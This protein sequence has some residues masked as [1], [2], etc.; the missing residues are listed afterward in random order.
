MSYINNQR[1]GV[2]SRY[3]VASVYTSPRSNQA[4]VVVAKADGGEDGKIYNFTSAAQAAEIFTADSAGKTMRGC[5]SV[6]FAAGVSRVVAVPVSDSQD[7][8]A[9]FGLIENVGGIGAVICD[10]TEVANLKALKLSVEKSSGELRERIAF[11]GATADSAK[12]TA[13][14]INSERFVLTA[15]S[16]KLEDGSDHPVYGAA[17][18]AG[19]VLAANDCTYNFS[20][21]KLDGVVSVEEMDEAKVQSL[22]LAGVTVLETATDSTAGENEAVECVRALTTKTKT[23]DETDYSMRGL[24]VIL[25]IDSVIQNIRAQLKACLRGMQLS[26]ASLAAVQSQVVVVLEAN[27]D[28]GVLQSY[29]LPKVYTDESDPTV[30]IVELAM[31]VAQVVS[32]IF[33]KAHIQI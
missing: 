21:E 16:V 33:V 14:Q 15:P 17:S 4:A 2:Y 12:T 30:C 19:M 6:L 27:K 25:S 3:E 28:R 23:A 7:Y 11:C 1:P 5:I 29:E 26:S 10:S 8:T 31:H 32:Q 9:A 13:E 24:N 22:L 18:M 20:G